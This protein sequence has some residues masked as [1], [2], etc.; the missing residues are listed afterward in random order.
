MANRGSQKKVV[1]LKVDFFSCALK[2]DMKFP[3]LTHLNCT[4]SGVMCFHTAVQQ[5]SRALLCCKTETRNLLNNN[6]SFSLLSGP[7]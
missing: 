1:F 3:T 2:K 6:S 5:V 4:V 7:W